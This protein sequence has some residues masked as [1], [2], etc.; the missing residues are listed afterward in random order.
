M[1]SQDKQ[2]KLCVTQNREVKTIQNTKFSQ[3]WEVNCREICAP[4]NSEMNISRKLHAK[5]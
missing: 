5:R 2:D 4:Q 1:L 3:N